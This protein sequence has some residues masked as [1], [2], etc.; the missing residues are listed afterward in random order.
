MEDNEIAV[1]INERLAK[2]SRCYFSLAPEV[3]QECIK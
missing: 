3:Y 2:G 1:E